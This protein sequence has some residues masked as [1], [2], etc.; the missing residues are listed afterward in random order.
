MPGGMPENEEGGKCQPGTFCPEGSSEPTNCTRGS[1]CSTPGLATASGECEAGWFCPPGSVSPWQVIC[2]A[3]SFCVNG[4]WLPEPCPVAT[5]GHQPNLRSAEGCTL[6]DAG[7]YCNETGA[8]TVSGICEPGFYCD[9]GKGPVS[10]LVQ[11][12]CPEGHFCPNLTHLSV[13]YPCPATTYNNATH[14]IA[15]EAC[16]PCPPGYYC[17]TVGAAQPDGLCYAGFYCNGSMIKPNPASQICPPGNYCPEGSEY[18]IPCP[19][20]TITKGIGNKESAAC[21]LCKPGNYCTPEMSRFGYSHPCSAG[22]ICVLGSSVPNPSNT[23]KGYIC[24]R[25]HY[26]LEGAVLETPCPLGTFGPALGSDECLPC[27][28]GCTCPNYGLIE[29]LPCPLGFFCP[30]ETYDQGVP[31]PKGTYNPNTGL[32]EMDEC[33]ACPAGHFCN[34]SG[35]SSPSGPCHPGYLCLANATHPGPNDGTNE[36]CPPGYYCLEGTLTPTPCPSGTLRNFTLGK[37]LSDCFPCT[38]GYFCEGTSLLGPTGDCS[39]G[40]Y[41]PEGAGVNV[42]APVGYLCPAGHYCINRTALPYA[43]P[44]GTWQPNKGSSDCLSCPTGSYCLMNATTPSPCLPWSYCPEG[45]D[46]PLLC[47]NG[48]YTSN[49]TRG[50]QEATQCDLCPTGKYCVGGRVAGNCTGGFWCKK[51]SPKPSPIGLNRTIGQPCPRGYFCPDG[52]VEPQMCPPDLFIDIEG[53]VSELECDY[54]PAGRICFTGVPVPQMCP[55]G[56]YCHYNE[57]I[58][59]CPARTYNDLLGAMN[60]TWCKPCPAG[61]W[62]GEE[63]MSNYSISPCPPGSYCTSA[64]YK[65]EP[66]PSSSFRKLPGAGGVADCHLCPP[67]RFCF[68]TNSTHPGVQCSVGYFCPIGS[69]LQ[70]LCL[71]GYFCPRAK[72][73]IPCPAGWYCPKGSILPKR[74]P[75]GHYCKMDICK[76]NLIGTIVPR[77]CP[78]GYKEYNHSMRATFNDT[79][80][81]CPPGYYGDHPDRLLCYPCQSGVVCLEG[82]TTD[83]PSVNESAHTGLDVT[84]SYVCPPGHY[85]PEMS[86]HPL[87]CTPGTYNPMQRAKATDACLLCDRNSF[88]HLYGQVGCFPCG[89]EANQPSPG[90]NTCVCKARGRYFQV[91]DYSC[92]CLPDHAILDVHSKDCVKSYYEICPEL[93]YRTQD[94]R[95]LDSTK[96]EAYC[97]MQVCDTPDD[98]ESFDKK[99]GLCK[100]RS[101]KLE[102]ICNLECRR[103]QKKLLKLICNPEAKM[104]IGFGTKDNDEQ[105]EL[106]ADQ[107]KPSILAKD[108]ILDDYCHHH[109]NQSLPMFIIG[110]TP[111]GFQGKYNP[112]TSAIYATLMDNA[113]EKY[114]NSS[115]VFIPEF[116]Q[117][118]RLLNVPITIGGRNLKNPTTC[119]NLGESILF[120]ISKDNYPVYDRFNLYN[121]NYNFDAG[122]FERLNEV[123]PQTDTDM[124]VFTYQFKEPGTYVFYLSSDSH[125]KLY[126]SVMEGNTSCPMTGPF[127]PTSSQN[128]VHNRIRWRKD[129]IFNL[130]WILIGYLIAMLVFLMICAF[131]VMGKFSYKMWSRPIYVNPFFRRLALEYN[132][133]VYSSRGSASKEG[134]SAAQP[135]GQSEATLLRDEFWDYAGQQ[136]A[137][138]FSVGTL[139]QILNKQS[140]HVR[141]EVNKTNIQAIEH[142]KKIERHLD[143]LKGFW[144]AKLNVSST[145]TS[146][147]TE[148]QVDDYVKKSEELDRELERRKRL[149]WAFAKQLSYQRRVMLEEWKEWENHQITFHASILEVRRLLQKYED[150]LLQQRQKSDAEKPQ[151]VGP[152][153]QA[154]DLIQNAL[155][156]VLEACEHT[157]CWGII[158]KPM[159]GQLTRPGKIE[160]LE[161]YDLIGTSEGKIIAPDLLYIDKATGLIRPRQEATMVT[162]N[163]SLQ[164][165][166]NDAFV[167]PQT[168]HVLPVAG[169]VGYA[170]ISGKLVPML[171]YVAAERSML[172]EPPIPFV[173]YPLNHQTGKPVATD[174]KPISSFA[175]LK[176]GSLIADPETDLLVPIVA[177]TIHPKSGLLYPVGGCHKD[178]ITGLLVAID[179]GSMMEDP[180]T[181]N[182]CQILGVT[183][184]ENSGK[185]IPVGELPKEIGHDEPLVRGSMVYQHMTDKLVKLRTAAF[186]GVTVVPSCGSYHTLLENV[187]F[188]TEQE[189]LDVLA[190]YSRTLKEPSK[191]TEH[192]TSS[193]TML[194]VS[195]ETMLRNL[196]KAEER[197]VMDLIHEEYVNNTRLKKVKNLSINGGSPGLYEYT[198]TGQL[199]PI[200]VGMT[201]DDPTGTG[202]ELPILSAVRDRGSGQVLPLATSVKHPETNDPQP[203]TIGQEI[204][205]ESS[206]DISHVTGLSIDPTTKDITLV[207]TKDDRPAPNVQHLALIEDEIVSCASFL[208]RMFKQESYLIQEEFELARSVLHNSDNISLE[209]LDAVVFSL[210]EQTTDLEK[211]AE[212]EWARENTTRKDIGNFLPVGLA[213]MVVDS[214]EALQNSVKVCLQAHG[215]FAAV[216]PKLYVKIKQ[217]EEK[218]QNRLSE[219]AEIKDKETIKMMMRRHNKVKG[220]LQMELRDHVIMK[221]EAID[222]VTSAVD[223]AAQRKVAV[224]NYAK[225][226][227]NDSDSRSGDVHF[228]MSGVFGGDGLP[229][230]TFSN[231]LVPVLKD[232]IAMLEQ[233]HPFILQV[234]AELVNPKKDS[235]VIKRVTTHQVKNGTYPD[236]PKSYDRNFWVVS[237]VRK[238][239]DVDC[240][241]TQRMLYQKHLFEVSSLEQTTRRQAMDT[242]NGLLASYHEEKCKVINVLKNNIASRF[243]DLLPNIVSNMENA[244]AEVDPMV[245]KEFKD[246]HQKL[247][248]LNQTMSE[249]MRIKC[250]ELAKQ[251]QTEVQNLQKLHVTE[252]LS[253]EVSPATL[254]CVVTPSLE[255]ME[256]DTAALAVQQADFFN[257]VDETLRQS[258]ILSYDEKMKTYQKPL[259]VD[260]EKKIH[261]QD[262]MENAIDSI[263]R[264][265]TTV[266]KHLA[267]DDTVVDGDGDAPVW[268]FCA[269]QS[270]MNQ[271]VVLSLL[272]DVFNDLERQ[273]MREIGI[274]VL[275]DDT[276]SDEQQK[277]AVKYKELVQNGEYGLYKENARQREMLVSKVAAHKHMAEV[278]DKEGFICKAVD[279]VCKAS[280]SDDVQAILSVARELAGNKDFQK[281]VTSQVQLLAQL[282]TKQ[283]KQESEL[284][285][286]IEINLD[287]G[288]KMLDEKHEKNKKQ[289]RF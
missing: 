26:C 108:M 102:E 124:T 135:P 151:D 172:D 89:G 127:F 268:E 249:E 39:E 168:G 122:D 274:H 156:D 11:Y 16:Q 55:K 218:F 61:Y 228:D 282:E 254:P 178:P 273:W 22:Y 211:M 164:N 146:K 173:S 2:P 60:T 253:K 101:E 7:H 46:V 147:V 105:F 278:L 208:R 142:Y 128:L 40:Y 106:P 280:T 111:I 262:L 115:Q 256:K 63:G 38:P 50:L 190:K 240:D 244:G 107:L 41:C 47:P 232:F 263:E 4:T 36:P 202:L 72:Y 131:I 171:D 271:H 21:E 121:S 246:L 196:E 86:V 87:P 272:G 8:V 42:S 159:G 66:C 57:T 235:S 3:G 34:M 136:D 43:C 32:S 201:M 259:N 24:P 116:I 117:K 158:G 283:H 191:S 224:M 175:S 187:I 251:R 275:S 236:A 54:C 215:K 203:I 270:E 45:S 114:R 12:F 37:T 214:D 44:P 180:V 165:V 97:K 6:C 170:P 5:Y 169:N 10:S 150:H 285:L 15:Q 80:Q 177:M 23:T 64:I 185:V 84:H 9:N 31:C 204:T 33:L 144:I 163:G 221:M 104:M 53:A 14:Q 288:C 181:G 19:K 28:E 137:E 134:D 141:K 238:S 49:A 237:D 279:R 17:Q 195:I 225:S 88:N 58:R 289:V 183:I 184:D 77:K 120:S 76:G 153:H 130:N 265:Q 284:E 233:D 125:K 174:L 252:A 70:Y 92:P 132:F 167:H 143:T 140:A 30:N 74:C 154:N 248:N 56:F 182:V 257:E 149:G 35:L 160:R 227:L 65:P 179:I 242:I 193:L 110:V 258:V 59:P 99:L 67:G 276:T 62:C 75:M 267:A 85:C 220:S 95:C 205:D 241:T 51:G 129:L 226:L 281:L 109:A 18:P 188:K 176:Y 91:T 29:P 145:N 200:L 239:D 199:L 222:F 162:P 212:R 1:Y 71:P 13:Q 157:G 261:A 82:A 94:G 260:Q 250:N 186:D 206:D 73:Q 148:G 213:A 264:L 138:T 83:R 68:L 79:C 48:T 223:R 118:R 216:L 247:T 209:K 78:L 113:K 100:C 194:K 96:W 192:F 69:Q 139:N 20:G 189:L 197:Y 25:G 93:S 98:Y 269:L 52:T 119:L 266:E 229:E 198:K 234:D 166:P 230:V 103:L 243:K 152:I 207:T 287:E 277:E 231:E 133:D 210:C 217:E 81:S 161:K 155:A 90:N 286:E 219:V 255:E 126:V 112:D 245:T 123:L 27:P